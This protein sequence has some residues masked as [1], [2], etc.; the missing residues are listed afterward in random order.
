MN[1]LLNLQKTGM[2]NFKEHDRMAEKGL[3]VLAFGYTE[4]DR[5]PES[6]TDIKIKISGL[7]GFIDPPKEGVKEAVEIAKEP[8]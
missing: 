5:K 6:L 3:R 7:V 1:H 8:E 2:K 4:V